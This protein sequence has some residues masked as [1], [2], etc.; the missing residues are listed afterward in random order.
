[1]KVEV[2]L[3]GRLVELLGSTHLLIEDATDTNT[4]RNRLE[5]QFPA[6][7]QV[8]YQVAVDQLIIHGNKHLAD[9]MT[10]ALMP[11]FSGG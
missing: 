3:F 2:L 11:P 4:V 5:E 6:L 10:V 7:K 8:K 9:G 1:M